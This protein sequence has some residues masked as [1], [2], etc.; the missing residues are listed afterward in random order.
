MN[1][2]LSYMVGG[3]SVVLFALLVV[4]TVNLTRNEAK[5]S[6]QGGERK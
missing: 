4:F 6:R 2:L 1:E 5:L 3:L